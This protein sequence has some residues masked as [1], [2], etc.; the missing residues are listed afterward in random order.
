MPQTLVQLINSLLRGM[1][2]AWLRNIPQMIGLILLTWFAHTYLLV[3]VNEGFNYDSSK[4]V[5]STLALQGYEIS[6]TLF[7]TVLGGLAST[8]YY[9]V[10]RGELKKT[11]A[12]IYGT[13]TWIRGS[14]PSARPP[15]AGST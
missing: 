12:N 5:S 10:R 7:W 15:N 14:F 11:M 2:K 6:G 13:P 4:L 9:K 3:V 1:I 8:V